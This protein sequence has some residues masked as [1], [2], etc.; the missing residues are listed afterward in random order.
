MLYHA[1]MHDT[2]N[3]FTPYCIISLQQVESLQRECNECALELQ[4]LRVGEAGR[5]PAVAVRPVSLQD[6]L[7]NLKRYDELLH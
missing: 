6:E 1:F 4:R 3:E 5:L 7:D 2:N